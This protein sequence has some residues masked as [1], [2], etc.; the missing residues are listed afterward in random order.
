MRF[1]KKKFKFV[2]ELIAIPSP[3]CLS[4]PSIEEEKDD[5][6]YWTRFS[7]PFRCIKL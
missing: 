7:Q 2:A 3:D 1:G 6:E 5:G 4:A